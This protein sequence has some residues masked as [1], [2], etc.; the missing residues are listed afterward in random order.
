LT[1]AVEEDD[2]MVT[3]GGG[4][5]TPSYKHVVVDRGKGPRGV[6]FKELVTSTSGSGPE[7]NHESNQEKRDHMGEE[8]RETQNDG[9]EPANPNGVEGRNPC[10][11]KTTLIP[12]VILEDPQSQLFRDQMNTHS[13]ICK[14]MGL[15]PTERMLHNW[16][17][18]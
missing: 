17:K 14:F 2:N 10:K 12:K 1:N 6:G 4:N 8:V 15:W 16:I 13:L 5:G 11:T 9:Q 3:I 18:Y 7:K